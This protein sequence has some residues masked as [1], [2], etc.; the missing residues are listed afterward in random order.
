MGVP[1]RHGYKPNGRAGVVQSGEG[2]PVSPPG[3]NPP[4]ATPSSPARS[5]RMSQPNIDPRA[6][7]V[8]EASADGY[9][10]RRT[11]AR[12]R[13]RSARTFVSRRSASATAAMT[14]ASAVGAWRGR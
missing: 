5:P 3:G 14:A 2:P 10:G 4:A 11:T 9:H 13:M 7:S 6:P 8:V 1:S 12:P